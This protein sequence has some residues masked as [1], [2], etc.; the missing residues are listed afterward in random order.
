MRKESP[1]LESE[2][3]R[4]CVTSDHT[5]QATV[6]TKGDSSTSVMD[7]EEDQVT[8]KETRHAPKMA[9]WC[10]GEHPPHSQRTMEPSGGEGKASTTTAAVTTRSAAKSVALGGL[11]TS[12]LVTTATCAIPATTAIAAMPVIPVTMVTP[13]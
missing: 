13:A 2:V 5:H 6:A 9:A 10:E 12:P 7:G 4:H 8:P 3:K 1:D 11:V